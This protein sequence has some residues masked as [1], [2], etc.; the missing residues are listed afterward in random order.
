[1]ICQAALNGL[2]CGVDLVDVGAM[3]RSNRLTQGRFA[4]TC[5]TNGELLDARGRPERLATRWAVKE[6]VCKVLGV[7]L[8]R[9]IGFHDIEVV[10]DDSGS[11]S[12]RL[13]NE[14]HRVSISKALTQWAISATHERDLAIAFVVATS[15]PLE[16]LSKRR[17]IKEG[18]DD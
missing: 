3:A 18:H 13:L 9:G 1:M 10:R 4:E 14:A 7:G 15:T 11:L 8:L 2:A 16:P 17:T 12:V 6:A 5:F